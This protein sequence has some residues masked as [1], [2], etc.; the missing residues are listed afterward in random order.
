M[1]YHL[2][3]VVKIQDKRFAQMSPCL[4]DLLYCGLSSELFEEL[5]GFYHTCFFLSAF[6]NESF[7]GDHPSKDT[8]MR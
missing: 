7:G 8:I 2:F 6:F 1:F 3:G 5:S 4:G